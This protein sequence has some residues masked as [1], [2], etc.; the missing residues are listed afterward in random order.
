MVGWNASHL[1]LL[2]AGL[3]SLS[4]AACSDQTP[5]EF[6]LLS[7]A[8]GNL[9]LYWGD[10]NAD[11]L[12]RLTDNALDDLQP[13]WS[14]NGKSLVFVSRVDLTNTELMRI[15][16][17]SLEI[18]RLTEN[19]A[20][21]Y[22]PSW[23]PDGSKIAFVSTRDGHSNIYVVNHDGTELRQL[24]SHQAKS[25]SPQ[26]APDGRSIAFILGNNLASV[27]ADGDSWRKLTN[28]RE[29]NDTQPAWSPD[30]SQIAFTR[31]LDEEF[32]IYIVDVES[33]EIVQLT[34]TA[35][36]DTDPVWS[37]DGQSIAWLSARAD[38]VRKLLY[39][40]RPDGKGVQQVTGPGREVM[41][42]SWTPD[43]RHLAF[44]RDVDGRFTAQVASING[45]NTVT[46]TPFKKGLDLMPRFRPM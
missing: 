32:D 20:L 5:T 21:D 17:P 7:N 2:V 13:S 1:V 38:G 9:E 22:S 3:I 28:A 41:T 34:K 31:R 40:A 44:V 33:G 26:W 14:P 46:L 4:L 11:E 23:S 30:G 45:G 42:P 10:V 39:R 37:P 27:T 43:G 25:E 19:P 24:T 15:D 8:E 18:S 12:T 35:G 29:V 16:F 6:V 36:L